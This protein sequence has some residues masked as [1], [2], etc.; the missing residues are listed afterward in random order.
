LDENF[1]DVVADTWLSTL[2]TNAFVAVV[3]MLPG[4]FVL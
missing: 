3:T 2:V 1:L 4:L